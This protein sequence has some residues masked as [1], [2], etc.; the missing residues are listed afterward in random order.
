[1]HQKTFRFVLI[2]HISIRILYGFCSAYIKCKNRLILMRNFT[3]LPVC[4]LLFLG[5]SFYLLA[6]EQ[7]DTLKTNELEKIVVVSYVSMNGIGHLKEIQPPVIYAGKR[8]EVIVVD[9][10]DGN[11]AIN[12]T[13]QI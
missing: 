1:M 3:K 7:K 13:R 8:T 4:C 10:V 9:S 6:Q 5:H 12:N 2:E 11:K